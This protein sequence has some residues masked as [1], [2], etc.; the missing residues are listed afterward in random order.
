M[1]SRDDGRAGITDSTRRFFSTRT[2]TGPPSSR[3]TRHRRFRPQTTARVEIPPK[4]KADVQPGLG[5]RVP[6][7][8]HMAVAWVGQV[9]YFRKRY[10]DL[11]ICRE[12]KVIRAHATRTASLGELFHA[13]LKNVIAFRAM[14][15]SAPCDVGIDHLRCK[16]SGK[17]PVPRDYGTASV[18][19]STAGIKIVEEAED[20]LTF[21]ERR[22]SRQSE[23]RSRKSGVIWNRRSKGLITASAR[24]P[25]R[26]PASLK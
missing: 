23:R 11:G 15:G 2:R 22:W 12:A 3:V 7:S 5:A 6:V 1:V 16:T 13:E 19:K 21:L 4:L 9:V 25:R 14:A 8:E 24:R 10:G 18:S 17:V 26:A 20:V